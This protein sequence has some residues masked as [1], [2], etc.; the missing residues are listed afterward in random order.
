MEVTRRFRC[1]GLGHVSRYCNRPVACVRC[2]EGHHV[3]RCAKTGDAVR[4]VNCRRA[5][6]KDMAH[7]VQWRG[8]P[9]VVIHESGW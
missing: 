3:T 7:S 9:C 2:G 1:Q 6:F 4:C 8:C 5:G